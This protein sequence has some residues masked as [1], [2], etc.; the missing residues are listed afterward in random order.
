MDTRDE[1]LTTM[2]ELLNDT[3]EHRPTILRRAFRSHG[4]RHFAV[5]QCGDVSE[6]YDLRIV[7]IAALP[8]WQWIT[9]MGRMRSFGGKPLAPII[10]GHRDRDDPRASLPSAIG[11]P[12]RPTPSTVSVRAPPSKAI[13]DKHAGAY[14]RAHGHGGTAQRPSV[15]I[16]A[17]GEVAAACRN[18]QRRGHLGPRGHPAGQPPCG[19]AWRR[20]CRRDGDSS[21]DLGVRRAAIDRAGTAARTTADGDRD[22]CLL[23]GAA[24]LL[25]VLYGITT[26]WTGIGVSVWA[27]NCGTAAPPLVLP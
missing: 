22:H 16:I 1:D 18:V 9:K 26:A 25:S 8:G 2:M 10:I 4:R 12:I 3:G 17:T 19:H 6:E 27:F 7:G 15:K 13:A 23:A 20:Q 11:C 14:E 24:C 5:R 21:P